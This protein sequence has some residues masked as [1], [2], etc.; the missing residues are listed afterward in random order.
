MIIS[1]SFEDC[2]V[3]YANTIP[4]LA[5]KSGVA[6]VCVLRDCNR[7]RL[8]DTI[9]SAW[10]AFNLVRMVRPDFVVSTG[11]APGLLAL[12]FGKLF[13]ARA[14]WIDSVAHSERLSMSGKLASKITDLHLTQWKHLAI[15]GGP[16]YFG[17]VL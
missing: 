13:G 5:E 9:L 6:G 16:Q 4:G 17:S 1:A 8:G 2:E 10:D 14:V 7:N 3:V 12:L 11:A 15:E